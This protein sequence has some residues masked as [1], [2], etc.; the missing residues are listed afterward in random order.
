MA[1]EK[2]VEKPV[3][4]KPIRNISAAAETLA[5]HHKIDL[6]TV[7]GTGIGG[8]IMKEDVEKAIAKNKGGK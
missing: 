8:R 6:Y 5:R 4:R 7:K 3:V 1:E 2:A